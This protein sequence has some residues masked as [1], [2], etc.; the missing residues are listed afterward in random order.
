MTEIKQNRAEE[1][2]KEVVTA[3]K[4]PCPTLHNSTLFSAQFSLVLFLQT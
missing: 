4:V 1:T 3:S 2:I